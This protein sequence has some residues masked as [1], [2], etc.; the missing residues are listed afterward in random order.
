MNVA[1]LKGAKSDAAGAA[2]QTIYAFNPPGYAVYRTYE[3]VMI[4]Y[5]DDSEEAKKQRAVIARLNPLRGEINSL[6]DNWRVKETAEAEATSRES[7]PKAWLRAYRADARRN[8]I[9][10]TEVYDRRVGDSLVVALEGDATGA[11]GLLAEVK[12]DVL[13]ERTAQARL[14]Y[15]TVAFFA[16]VFAVAAI[17]W[18]IDYSPWAEA[19]PK[20]GLQKKLDVRDQW[21]AAAAGA[22]GAFFS[23][24]VGVR[25]RTILPDL[26]S[27]SAWLDA[28]LRIVV[29]TI[30]G[31]MLVALLQLGTVQIALGEVTLGDGDALEWLYIL[32]AG[33]IGGFSE[34]M[35]P[36]LLAKAAAAPAPSP[37]TPSTDLKGKDKDREKDAATAA[38]AAPGAAAQPEAEAHD[39][40]GGVDGCLHD[41][42]LEAAEATPDDRLPAAT[43]GVAAPAAPGQGG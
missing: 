22:A 36:D 20:K 18:F 28:L 40:E 21:A 25:G 32:V 27:Y 24:A 15:V 9:R 17:W 13:G 19:W 2:V 11:E 3:R 5:A 43:G 10:K 33:F 26:I 39:H 35:V 38:A 12:R 16:F 34:R 8:R 6:V 30:A 31:S 14:V 7:G 41:H 42:P 29:G 1:D 37:N 23:V 4:H